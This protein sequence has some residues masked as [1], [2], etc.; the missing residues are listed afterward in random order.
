MKLPEQPLNEDARIRE[1]LA[2]NILDTEADENLDMIT[3]IASS[4]CGTP[5]ALISLI[6]SERQW[7][8]S[9]VGLSATET[10]RDYAFCAHAINQPDEV[11]MVKDSTKDERFFDNPLVTGE[12]H[13]IFYC[14]VPILT[15]SGHAIGTV[16]AIDSQPRE[17]NDYQINSL[18]MLAKMA[19]KFIKSK[20]ESDYLVDQLSGINYTLENAGDFFLKVESDGTLLNYGSKWQ[21]I[22]PGLRSGIQF[23]ELFVLEDYH[24]F[25]DLVA[26]QGSRQVIYFKDRDQ[27]SYKASIFSL[28]G[29]FMLMSLP[30]VSLNQR[31]S[32]YNLKEEDFPNYK[33]LSDFML[34]SELNTNNLKDAERLNVRISRQNSELKSALLKIEKLSSFPDQNPNPVL[35]I[36]RDLHILYANEKAR[37]LLTYFGVGNDFNG[38]DHLSELVTLLFKGIQKEFLEEVVTIEQRTFVF[39]LIYFEDHDFVNV[40]GFEVT[41][42]TGKIIRQGEE[43]KELNQRLSAQEMFLHNILDILPADVALFDKEMRFRFINRT[44]IKDDEAR[45]WIIGKNEFEYAEMRGLPKSWAEGRKIYFDKMLE[46]GKIV[47]W[48]EEKKNEAGEIR[49]HL[50]SYSP[51]VSNDKSSVYYIGYGLDITDTI[52]SKRALEELNTNL[53]QIIE[54]KTKEN[55]ELNATITETEKLVAIGELT[56]GIAHD[57]NSPIA[58]IRIGAESIRE[59]LEQLFHGLIHDCTREELE[60]ACENA[61]TGSAIPIMSG[62]RLLKERSEIENFLIS[63]KNLDKQI[64][65]KLAEGL[66]KAKVEH[67]QIDKIEKVLQSA[68]PEKMLQLMKSVHTIRQMVDT[69]FHASNRS[70]DVVSDLRKFTKSAVNQ[71]KECVNIK[72]SVTNVLRVLSSNLKGNIDIHLELDDQ[73]CVQA[74]PRDIFQVW[75]NVLKNAFEAIGIEPG[76]IWIRSFERDQQTIVQFENNGPHIPKEMLPEIFDRFRSSKGSDNSGFG[77]NIVKRILDANNWGVSIHSEKGST[78]FE[79]QL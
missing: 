28:E 10:P 20:N 1:L 34:L 16:C 56:M 62:I 24:T 64:A 59:T 2:L 74:V 26:T 53:E 40:Y 30:D 29:I 45:K 71:N 57:L 44:S 9:R 79:F 51:S 73:C 65:A 17:L 19:A 3:E 27:R 22:I 48:I 39:S 67:E 76:D 46:T 54:K 15:E 23:D 37:E 6:D 55:I 43:L 35:R 14:G 70:A 50:R 69:I 12:P 5:I 8:K 31:L 41:N 75:S 78:L 60:F 7:F 11:F 68:H 32:S 13:V 25:S 72:E 21:K 52:Q 38:F 58:S 36:S 49:Y 47:E 63:E 66:V 33:E 18:R 42:Y 4:V 61:M 77:L